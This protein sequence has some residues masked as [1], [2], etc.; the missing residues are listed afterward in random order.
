LVD[1]AIA[2]N[3]LR[4]VVGP[5]RFSEEYIE[6]L[7]TSHDLAPLP[8]LGVLA[9]KLMPDVVVHPKE[10]EEVAEIV[11][12]A[13]SWDLPI[14]PRGG[15]SWGFGGAVP[16]KGGVLIDMTSM[17]RILHL[18]EEKGIVRVQPG[19]V[20]NML[21]E[22]IQR[23]GYFLPY[24][25][26]SAPGAT[27]GGWISTG[28]VGIGNYKYGAA[29]DNVRSLQIVLPSGGILD[30][31]HLADSRHPSQFD[32]TSLFIGAEGSLGIVT[33]VDLQVYPKPEE[34]RVVSYSFPDMDSAY[35][36]LTRITETK[37]KPY[38]V[39]FVDDNYFRFL[40]AMGREAPEVGGMVN[41]AFEGPKARV[42]EELKVFDGVISSANGKRESEETALHEWAERSYELR[43]KKL[44]TG[45]VIGEALIP[46]DRAAVVA[47]ETIELVSRMKM[48]L[49][50]NGI[51]VDRSTVAFLPFYLTD[52]RRWIKSVSSLSFIKK[53]LDIAN[54][55]GGRPV[56]LG[57]FMA[58]NLHS[59]RDNNTVEL[60]RY[61][62]DTVDPK[63]RIN[64][65]K[66]V[67]MV[68]RYGIGIGP[69]LFRFGMDALALVKRI[70]PRDKYDR[71]IPGGFPGGEH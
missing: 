22:W 52:E 45:A 39:G 59:M 27:I 32:L 6:R 10:P 4:E 5:E 46:I 15:A 35:G 16:N 51:L 48:N 66:T 11:R 21:D 65:G 12:V 55:Y 34:F 53:F 50:V 67:R 25:P 7:V 58:N 68:T 19:V 29:R 42:E 64:G 71:S 33:S 63:G 31:A 70:F 57:L 17:N 23:K 60:L 54:S 3:S 49:A 14:T 20:W 8:K 61:I 28:G 9:F 69:G 37:E 40:R 56:G 26:S 1:S 36:A 13:N 18:D 62:K 47:R 24:Y 43:S 2:R 41:L 38:H 44:G 30:T